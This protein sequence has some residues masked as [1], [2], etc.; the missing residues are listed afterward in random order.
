MAYHTRRLFAVHEAA[1]AIIQVCRA[2]LPWKGIHR[3]EH[4]PFVAPL[5]PRALSLF[6]PVL[7]KGKENTKEAHLHFFKVKFIGATLVNKIM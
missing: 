6:C 4:L 1:L 3:P 7:T 5:S 2:A